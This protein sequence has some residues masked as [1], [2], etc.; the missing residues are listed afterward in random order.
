MN[1]AEGRRMFRHWVEQLKTFLG[2]R[3][4]ADEEE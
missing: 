2:Q 1:S 4:T 3:Y